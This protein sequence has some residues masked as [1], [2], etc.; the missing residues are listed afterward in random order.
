MVIERLI[1]P[2]SSLY[3]VISKLF[4][5]LKIIEK[6]EVVSWFVPWTIMAAGMAAKAGMTDRYTFWEF[7]GWDKG[8]L[9]IIFLIIAMVVYKIKKFSIL[10]DKD[11]ISDKSEWISRSILYFIS[12]MLGWG[13]TDFLS[14]IGWLFGYLP[15]ILGISLLYMI[16]PDDSN[17]IIF[18]KQIGFSSS[19][20]FL[21]SCFFGWILDDPV[22]A[23]ASIVMFPFTVILT[24]TTH[25]RHIQRT[26]IY[27]LFII[28]G[29]VI[30]RQGWFI[31]PSLFLFYFLRFYNYFI[32]KKV[33]PGFAV[34]Q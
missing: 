18:R 4:T 24:V 5:S 2:D 7:S 28:M 31:F 9:S 11:N 20:L 22:L 33:F 14:G 15:M 1:K 30:A 23:T 27:P 3:V 19:I 26:H 13:I 16:E 12:W 10:L 6:F 29:F 34:D 21:L 25:H 32:Y 17:T 8:L